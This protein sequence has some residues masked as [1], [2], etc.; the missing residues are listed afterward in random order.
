MQSLSG[1]GRGVSGFPGTPQCPHGGADGLF[2]LRLHGCHGSRR[3]FQASELPSTKNMD[4][5]RQARVGG[6]A[7]KGSSS[8][9]GHSP[10]RGQRGAPPR[11]QSRGRRISSGGVGG[12]G[13]YRYQHYSP[14]GLPFEIRVPLAF[15]RGFR[16]TLASVEPSP[17]LCTSSRME[18]PH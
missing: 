12:V 10:G 17:W 6:I 15:I 3:A 8:Q 5:K 18:R 1:H 14:Q 2:L 7:G 16:V 9:S 13:R 11:G 4:G